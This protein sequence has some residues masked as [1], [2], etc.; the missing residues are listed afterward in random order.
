MSAANKK[1]SCSPILI[2]QI[3]FIRGYFSSLQLDGTFA[4]SAYSG[5]GNDFENRNFPV[6]RF[7]IALA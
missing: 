7:D 6:F 5:G 2:R 1:N 3:R 4:A